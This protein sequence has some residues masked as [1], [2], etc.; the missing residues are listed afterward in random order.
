MKR[1]YGAGTLIGLLMVFGSSFVLIAYLAYNLYVRQSAIYLYR[2]HLRGASI[3]ADALLLF[4][5]FYLVVRFVAALR[6][7]RLVTMNGEKI[8]ARPLLPG[9]STV[10]V[11]LKDV[12]GIRFFAN[13]T[14]PELHLLM[15]EKEIKVRMMTNYLEL[16]NLYSDLVAGGLSVTVSGPSV[17]FL[18]MDRKALKVR[19]I[20][21]YAFIFLV[22]ILAFVRVWYRVSVHHYR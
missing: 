12:T 1:T 22:I 8:V 7:N 21:V 18:E 13:G 6:S 9:S 3:F 17:R 16:Q 11:E 10:T 2:H 4:A 20:L 14:K 5:F 15:P 19:I